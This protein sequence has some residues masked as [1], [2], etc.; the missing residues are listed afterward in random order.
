MEQRKIKVIMVGIGHAHAQGVMEELLAQSDAFHVLGYVENHQNIIEM[1]GNL[2][3]FHKLERLSEEQVLKQTADKI[4][5]IFIETEME[6]LVPAARTYLSL[7]VPLHVDKPTG[8]SD[9]FLTLLKEAEAMAV[10]IQLGYMYRY[11]P[12]VHVA[13]SY[14]KDQRIGEISF[15]HACMNTELGRSQRD[16]LHSFPGGAMYVY[17]C[18]ML[19]VVLQFQG[20]PKQIHSFIKKSGFD[21]VEAEDHTMALLEYERGISM[22]QANCSDAN[23]YGRRQIVLSG[24]KGSI[25]IKPLENPTCM[26]YAPRDGINTYQNKAIKVDLSAYKLHRRYYYMVQDFARLVDHAIEDLWFP[27]N[28]EYEKKLH[29]LLMQIVKVSK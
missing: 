25:E 21:Q 12:A 14:L 11:N 17:G 1:K 2:S 15:I 9:E 3:P 10:P 22:I 18:H 26:T 8:V 16:S 27:M 6:E 4:D 29:Q 23:G 13:S 5:A 7:R 20:Y 19:D 28:Y 24:S